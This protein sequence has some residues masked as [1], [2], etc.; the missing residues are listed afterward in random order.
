[1]TLHPDSRV[2][3]ILRW[4]LDQDRP[5]STAA[6][7]A[8][9]GLSQRVIRYRLGAAESVLQSRRLE[10]I[11]Q[12]GTGLW[13]RG[14]AEAIADLRAE[15]AVLS[16]TPRVYAREERQ[17]VLL[18]S[19]LWT[20]P[21]ATSV[22]KLQK[23]LEVSNPSARRDLR[24]AEEW[25]ERRGLL[26][27]RRPGVGISLVGT[28]TTLRK[29]LVQLIV[30]SVP[31]DVLAELCVRPF[32]DARLVRVR[33]P[34]G[35][36]DYLAELPM[37]AS[38][39]IVA[40][41]SLNGTLE[42]GNSDLVFCVYLAVVATRRAAGRTIAFD[43]GQHRSL[44]DHPVSETAAAIA[45][46]FEAEFGMRLPD[47]EV[48]GVTE[49]LL[50]LATLS[51]AEVPSHHEDLVDQL[52]QCVSERLHPTLGADAELRRSLALHLER[53]AVRLRYGLP[54]HNPLL[55]EVADRYPKAHEVAGGLGE[56]ISGYFDAPIVE[57]E[58]GYITMYL[59]GALERSRLLPGRRV[60]VVCPSGM[61]TAWVLVSRIQ[62][63]LPQLQIVDVLSSRSYEAMKDLDVDLVISTV[64]ITGDGP[65]VVVVNPLLTP[66]DVRHVS[67]SL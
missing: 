32:K 33:V 17:H 22:E 47:A 56:L 67:D 8:D 48:A 55:H 16:K 24:R 1:M 10:L 65:P 49:Y 5:R 59:S 44:V 15:L 53:L 64:D 52:M 20:A 25:L 37:E 9:L 50:G 13:V 4:L 28:E 42:E 54:V 31:D 63:E 6:L 14:D 35:L 51:S 26:L 18:A 34:A 7:A 57:D 21:A 39:R 3:R 36:H 11:R 41:C 45:G 29:A 19:L 38:A 2:V 23:I 46:A 62:A 40:R 58:V 66:T 60:L 12:R 61:A 27:A 43:A 30:E